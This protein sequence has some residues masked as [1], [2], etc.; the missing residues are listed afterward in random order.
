MTPRQIVTV[1]L[2]V[3][4][5]WLGIEVLRFLPSFFVVDTS[6]RAFIYTLFTLAITGVFSLALWFFPQTFAGRIL[7]SDAVTSPPSV[8]PD[9]WLAMGCSLIGLWLLSTTLP[10]LAVDIFAFNLMSA[11]SGSDPTITRSII[12][13]VAEVIIGLWL[14]LGA[15]GFRTLFWWAQNA[16]INKTS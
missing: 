4:A 6:D 13:Y 12:Y 5:I 7:S 2:R 3:L 16:G 1:A 11:A 15:R 14:I 10:R 8:T 9:M